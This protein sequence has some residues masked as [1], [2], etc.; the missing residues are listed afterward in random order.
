[1]DATAVATIFGDFTDSVSTI[2]TANLGVVL[3]AAAGLIG[4][5]IAVRYFKKHVGR[6]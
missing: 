1:M 3:L 4:L 2:L 5:G 6:K